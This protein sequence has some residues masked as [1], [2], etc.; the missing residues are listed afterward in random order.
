MYHR[1]SHYLCC[2]ILHSKSSS[3]DNSEMGRIILTVTS[4][5]LL[6]ISFLFLLISLVV[7]C[8]SGK[9]FFTMDI[10]LSHFNHAV[11][12]LLAVGSFIFLVQ[13]V[14]KVSWLCTIAA[15]LLHFL[16]TNVFISSLPIAILVFYSIWI[17]KIKH[18]ARKL[19]KY[20]IPV[21]WS[22]SSGLEYDMA[23]GLVNIRKLIC[24]IVPRRIIVN[25]PAF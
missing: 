20:M 5:M 15:F 24:I 21:G 8:I 10:N 1:T 17:V 11:S 22:V 12:L 7:F 23:D 19:S 13:S 14:S 16:W 2:V 6:T 9:R 3:G 4:Y 25:I 18:T